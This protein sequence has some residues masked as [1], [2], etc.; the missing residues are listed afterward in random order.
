MGGKSRSRQ[1]GKTLGFISKNMLLGN[2]ELQLGAALYRLFFFKVFLL[3]PPL[4]AGRT[5][6]KQLSERHWGEF[7]LAGGSV[8]WLCCAQS[9]QQMA[10]FPT[11]GRFIQKKP[12][13]LWK[14]DLF[15]G[16]F[17]PRLQPNLSHWEDRRTWNHSYPLL[18]KTQTTYASNFR[19]LKINYL[20]LQLHY[21]SKQ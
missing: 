3:S 20:K 5:R 17:I 16:E 4:V 12:T 2:S 15:W 1:F 9:R 19:S 21:L 8:R 18:V 14:I 13:L 11:V 10:P 6:I 7:L